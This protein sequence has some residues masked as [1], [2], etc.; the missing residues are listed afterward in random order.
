MADF[1]SQGD[2]VT[3]VRVSQADR[4]KILRSLPA[5]NTQRWVTRRKAQ[6]VDAV[7]SGVLTDEEVCKRYSISGEELQS[8]IKLHDEHGVQALRATRIQD[9]RS[10]DTEQQK[11]P[12][13]H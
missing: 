2:Q 13:G 11:T 3:I 9:Y 7:K 10:K 6:V 8:W 4:E 1:K 12:V 5:R